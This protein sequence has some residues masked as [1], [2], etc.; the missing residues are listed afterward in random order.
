MTWMTPLLASTSTAVTVA[1]AANRKESRG[2]QF[3]T[4]FPDRNDEEWLKHIDLSLNGA[5]PEISYSEVTMT[6]WEP[7]ERTY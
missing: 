2:A 1:G 4:D 7:Q 6:Q 5:G 3:R